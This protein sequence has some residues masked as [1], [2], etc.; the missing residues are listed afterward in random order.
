MEIIYRADDGTEFESAEECREYENN[1]TELMRALKNG[2][3]AYD[4]DGNFIDFSEYGF[5]D[6]Y[7]AFNSV[8]FVT[9]RNQEALDMFVVKA[10]EDFGVPWF[11]DGLNKPLVVGEKYFYDHGDREC[12]VCLEDEQKKLNK[13]AD[14]FTDK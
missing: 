2:V 9:F 10:N 6:L 3:F 8:F 11:Q 4:R 7:N 13:I 1:A 12:W 14:V 5:D